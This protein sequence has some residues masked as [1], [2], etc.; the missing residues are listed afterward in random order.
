M[1][2]T[3]KHKCNY[4]DNNI[5]LIYSFVKHLDDKQIKFLYDL[6]FQNGYRGVFAFIR[7]NHSR[8]ESHFIV[9]QEE[10]INKYKKTYSRDRFACVIM[11]TI[12]FLYYSPL[13]IVTEVPQVYDPSAAVE[14]G[15][16][17][18]SI[19]DLIIDFWPFDTGMN[20]FEAKKNAVESHCYIDSSMLNM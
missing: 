14:L 2:Y 5:E 11:T 12:W 9:M 16:Q 19:H 4:V 1:F 20:P 17:F 7:K 8:M 10:Q 6:I 18:F 15:E 3:L 13:M